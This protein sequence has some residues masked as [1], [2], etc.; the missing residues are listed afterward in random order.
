MPVQAP[1]GDKRAGEE[2]NRNNPER[3]TQEGV[4]YNEGDHADDCEQDQ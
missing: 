1:L 3:Q 4:L 2:P